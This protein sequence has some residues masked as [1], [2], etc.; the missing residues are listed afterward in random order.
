MQTIKPKQFMELTSALLQNKVKTD[1][2]FK[3]IPSMM[4]WGQPG[5]GKTASVFQLA[6]EIESIAKSS[7]KKVKAIVTVV[8][9]T[10]YNPVDL[11]GIPTAN[12][13][14]TSAIW[15]KPFI[16]DLKD[17]A[18]VN[19]KNGEVIEPQTGKFKVGTVV[20]EEYRVIE[21]KNCVNYELITAVPAFA[22]EYDVVNLFFLDELSAAPASL[23]VCAYQITHDR[24]IG[25]HKLPKNTYPICAGNRTTDKSV[26]FAMPKALSNR[27]IHLEFSASN[28]YEESWMEWAIENEVDQRIIAFLG[29]RKDLLNQFSANS[30]EQAFATP[31]SWENVSKILKQ[32]PDIK[33]ARPLIAGTVGEGPA[34]EF[35]NYCRVYTKLP[36]LEDITSGK[37]TTQYKEPD[38]LY[39]ISTLLISSLKSL[40][41]T[42]MPNVITYIN[43]MPIEFSVMTG[44][45]FL[46]QPEHAKKFLKIKEWSQWLVTGGKYLVD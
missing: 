33:I 4:L 28:F 8:D 18:W 22:E 29:F 35:V 17:K 46:A 13:D 39:A 27:V 12:E 7:G 15:L 45:A 6:D 9:L 11:R 36:R 31:R 14:K 38:I 43:N 26:A 32:I 24:R 3:D 1:L 40:K 42:D 41:E 37:F 20:G 10:L 34:I 16:L 23:Q 44:R 30:N 5:V 21:R 25:E 19:P 2:N